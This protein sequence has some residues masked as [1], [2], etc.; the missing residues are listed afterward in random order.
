MKKPRKRGG[1]KNEPKKEGK[2]TL[3][4]Q[5][6]HRGWGSALHLTLLKMSPKMCV[7]VTLSLKRNSV[8]REGF[9]KGAVDLR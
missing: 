2:N 3:F 1:T 6:H 8:E 9:N 5:T 7:S 4:G